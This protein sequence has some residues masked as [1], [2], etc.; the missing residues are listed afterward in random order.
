M[1][2][3]R[4]EEHGFSSSSQVVG[5]MRRYLLADDNRALAENLAEILRDDG[6]EVVIANEGADALRLLTSTTFDALITDMRMPVLSGGGLLKALRAVDPGLPV[7]VMT[8]Y[9]GESDLADA[10]HSGVLA[11]LP[12][13]VPIGHLISL[14]QGARRN[15]LVAIVE[16]DL[17]LS[18]NLGEALRERG[19]TAVAATSALE[20]E[21]LG[22]VRPFVA[23]V[24]LNVPGTQPGALLRYLAEAFPRLPLLVMSGYP[25]L[26]PG[27]AVREQFTKPFST[28]VLLATIER[29]HAS[30]PPP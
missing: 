15:G 1:S 20:T 30:L 13:P 14:A 5:E 7:L 9:T 26:V 18:N 19:F 27:V 3:G 29:I 6:A 25:D 12:K 8:A 22:D 10:R 17:N 23:L 11:V 24:D 4:V 28:E 2:H 16:D 21:R